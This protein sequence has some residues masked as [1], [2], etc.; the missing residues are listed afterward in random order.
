MNANALPHRLLRPLQTLTGLML[1]GAL[2]AAPV[3]AQEIYQAKSQ[4]LYLPIYSHLWHGNLDKGGNPDKS[5]LSALVSVRN[6]D[7]KNPIKVLSARYYD[8]DG[9]LLKDFVPK[10]RT[11]PPLGTLELFIERREDEG[12]SG[13]NFLIRWQ[14]EATVNTPQVEAVHVDLYSTKALSFITSA[15]PIAE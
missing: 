15:R 14:A 6:T 3:Q 12:G 10:V 9:K 5:Y 4:T 11:I 8:T 7:T 2:L 1:A 13:A